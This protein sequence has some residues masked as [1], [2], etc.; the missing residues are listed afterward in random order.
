MDKTKKLALM[1]NRLH[2]LEGTTKNI[3]C[4]GVVRALKREIKNLE[5]AIE[6]N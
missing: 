1:Q 6:T 5:K 2:T 4:G 3:K